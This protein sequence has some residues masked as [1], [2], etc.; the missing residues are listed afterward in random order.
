M[1]A[2]A[3]AECE[4]AEDVMRLAR[5]SALRRRQW[6][7][8]PEP[9]LPDPPPEPSG[10]LTIG[11]APVKSDLTMVF[12]FSQ[13]VYR[14][15]GTEIGYIS[16][17]PSV[18]EIAKEVSRHFKI[19]LTDLLSE[20][21]TKDV[22]RPRQVAMYLAKKLTLRSLPDIARKLGGRDHTTILH[23]IRK[24]TALMPDDPDLSSHIAWLTNRLRRQ[25]NA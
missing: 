9:K 8:R 5:E 4:T 25:P 15:N 1:P 3:V 6:N 19:S 12:E 13:Q 23:G 22:V 7:A 24:I 2:I 11:G 14:L 20:R 16:Y 10:P 21:R 18:Q 17:R